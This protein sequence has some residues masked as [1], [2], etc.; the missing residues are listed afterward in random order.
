[1]DAESQMRGARG[2]PMPALEANASHRSRMLLYLCALRGRP[3]L[4]SALPS[5]F[6]GWVMLN[7]S[8]PPPVN[9]DLFREQKRAFLSQLAESSKRDSYKLFRG[10]RRLRGVALA[11]QVLVA[12]GI[13]GL[14]LLPSSHFEYVAVLAAF[15]GL[16]SLLPSLASSWERA[17]GGLPMSGWHFRM[18]MLCEEMILRLDKREDPFLVWDDFIKR[19]SEFGEQFPLGGW[20]S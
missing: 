4:R 3:E 16:A 8:A 14:G 6:R 5:L 9:V 20:P 10:S 11:G 15:L 18:E 13:A 17:F 7:E 2:R 1:L 12:C 19:R